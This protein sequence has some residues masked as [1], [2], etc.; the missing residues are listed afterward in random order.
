VNCS[1]CGSENE[2]GRKF[3]GE[4]GSSLMWVCAACG[5]ANAPSSKY[6]GEC[7]RALS[8]AGASGTSAVPAPASSGS[9]RR[10][11]TVLFADLVGFTTLSESRDPEEVR[12]LLTRYFD[13]CRS[14]ITRY[15]GT[16]EKFIGDAVMAVWGTPMAQE[17]DA[18]RGVRAALD[19][20][21]GVATLGEE[22][23]AAGL[24]ARAGVVTGEAAVT[25]GAEGQGMVAGDLVNTAS[26]IQ[27]VAEPG[28]VFVSE[29][30]KRAAEAAVVFADAG[31]HVLKGKA[32]PVRLWRA[33]RVVALVGGA[34]KSTGLEAP[35]VG[36]DGEFRLIKQLFHAS[37][38]E[39]KA[40][41]V[42]IAGIA[43]IGKSR[44][45]WE[46]LKYIDGL[47]DVVW[48]HRGRCL[49]Y[50]DGVTYWAL[51]EMVRMRADILEQEEP[52]SALA[53]LRAALETHVVDDDERRWMEPRL[54]HL[55]GLEEQGRR[56]PEDLFGAWRRFFERLAETSPTVLVFEDLQ[57]AD[58]GL[59]DF[60]E[61]LMEWSRGHALFV[62]TLA[63]P[64][65][66]TK[67][68][69]WGAGRRAFTSL[70]LEPLT[71]VAMEA[72]LEGLAPGLPSELTARILDRAEGVPL[73]AV[74]T[75]RMLIDRGLLVAGGDRYDVA[76]PI[77]ALE[78]PE[79]LHALIAA[80]ID[81]LPAEERR[82]I[83]QAAVLGKT[84]TPDALVAV[85]G[86]PRSDVD[87][88]LSDLVRREVLEHLD[89]PQSP[90]RGQFGFLQ[91]L[92]KRVAY[93]TLSKRDRKALHLATAAYLEETTR[94]EGGEFVEIVAAHY[95][96]AYSAVPGDPDAA[97][98]KDRACSALAA[99]GDRAASLAAKGEAQ[100]YF[101][102]ALE[103]ADDPGTRASLAER[104]GM[105]AAEGVRS[106]EARRHFERAIESY[107]SAG[108]AHAA[109]RVTARLGEV[110]WWQMVKLEEAV[111]LMESAMAEMDED[112][113][114]AD[115][116]F[117]KAQVGRL[118]YFRGDLDLAMTWIERALSDAEAGPYPEALS[119][120]LNTKSL[121]L[122]SIGRHRESNV[123]LEAALRIAVEADLGDARRRA[124]FNLANVAALSDRFDQ[125]LEYD[126]ENLSLARRIG[127]TEDE[128]NIATHL[129]WNY[130]G[131]GRWDDATAI[132]EEL[133]PD[134]S[135]P[136]SM[137]HAV[138]GSLTILVYLERGEIAKADQI[139][140]RLS[141][142]IGES[143]ETQDRAFFLSCTALIE[144]AHGRHASTLEAAREALSLRRVQGLRAVGMA[145]APALEAAFQLEDDDALEE[146][147]AVVESARPSEPSIWQRGQTVRYRA[148][149]AARKGDD[150][151]A[152]AGFREAVRLFEQS[153]PQPFWVAVGKLELG[154][155]LTAA[156][157]GDEAAPLLA[158][159]RATFEGLRATP[160]IE[161]MSSGVA[162]VDA[163]TAAIA[164]GIAPQA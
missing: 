98:L 3:C 29:G 124:L 21:T 158:D 123:L 93:D 147:L 131:L 82:L 67:R 15:G 71:V 50:G 38:D 36:R 23:R 32:E 18:E 16:V 111:E 105:A 8:Q 119:Q 40:H 69:T 149:L 22:V 2:S 117:F 59:L 76:G 41:L 92:V 134:F 48:W 132:V 160:W 12:E 146:V 80:R 126:L 53:K 54:A 72:L 141:E 17:D 137:M 101:E 10:L 30:T 14:L 154:E 110:M 75:V 31:S 113:P 145:L 78:V 57:W 52:A 87:G 55:L 156:D 45:S 25:V 152:E 84:F 27:S 70:A 96:E 116:A 81:G 104:A 140:R 79:S 46:F 83:Q 88:S 28:T 108:Q 66:L 155:W 90:E 127:S 121:V 7:G 5:T 91:D 112:E 49:S 133:V 26:R 114:D 51:A 73:Y 97:D 161:R 135:R 42:S 37:A 61:Y 106:E 143:M 148:K 6:C 43:G 64:E 162:A 144:L 56:E 164:G 1:V 153:G 20:V 58:A 139:Y 107:R 77:D 136:E 33:L 65:L 4:C 125:A 120:A 142:I 63:R 138:I 44:L 157:R 118:H 47:A 68:P 150:Q 85:S 19:L 159:A 163:P 13:L 95:L 151:G 102:R 100:K 115:V 122:A 86:R 94:S 11:V 74:E 99:A 34:Q 130:Y 9:E 60:I 89:D 109:A 39:R 129:V 103:L 62:V 128:M 35:F 24:A